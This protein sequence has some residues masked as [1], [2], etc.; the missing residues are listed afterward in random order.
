MADWKEPTPNTDYMVVLDNLKDLIYKSASF[1]AGTGSDTNIPVNSIRWFNNRFQKY[2]GN[3]KDLS[4]LYEINVTKFDGKDS[5]HYRNLATNIDN[6]NAGV[7][8]A[9]HFNDASHSKRGNGELH[10]VATTTTEGFMSAADKIK[11]NNVKVFSDDGVRD[12]SI[13]ASYQRSVPEASITESCRDTVTSI[14]NDSRW[15]SP[16][17]LHDI[18][19]CRLKSGIKAI[20]FNELHTNPDEIFDV[21]NGQYQF[22]G[23]PAGGKKLSFQNHRD[24]PYTMYLYLQC[25]PSNIATT[26]TG[27]WQGGTVVKMDKGLCLLTVNWDGT[28]YYYMVLKDMQMVA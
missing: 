21:D 19:L 10:D 5:A 11:L 23:I 20:K 8:A 17:R 3:W 25:G 1:M 24:R 12:D 7:L 14:P 28:N 26:P 18:I 9:G 4:S 16:R 22:Y 15:Y 13:K 6:V 2:D 27:Y